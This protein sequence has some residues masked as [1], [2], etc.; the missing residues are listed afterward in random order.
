MAAN[1]SEF[2]KLSQLKMSIDSIDTSSSSIDA[3]PVDSIYMSV[4]STSL[5]TFICKGGITWLRQEARP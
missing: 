5:A 2:V 4:N 3:Y 1:G